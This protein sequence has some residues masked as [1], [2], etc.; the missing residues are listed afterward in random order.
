MVKGTT[1][2]QSGGSITAVSTITAGSDANQVVMNGSNGTFHAGTGDKQVSI[3]AADATL[4]AGSADSVNAVKLDGLTGSVLAGVSPTSAKGSYANLNSDG[5]IVAYGADHDNN[6][7][8]AGSDGSVTATGD[9]TAGALP[10]GTEDSTNTGVQV[11]SD[12]N[13][14]ATGDVNVGAHWDDTT[15]SLV[16]NITLDGNTGNVTTAEGKFIAGTVASESASSVLDASGLTVTSDDETAKTVKVTGSDATITAQ[17]GT[18]KVTVSGDDGTITSTGN[19]TAGA[20]PTAD[21]QTATGV[22]LASA[23]GDV[24]ATGDVKVGAH[25]DTKTNS[26]VSNIT[27]D[28]AT[29][30]ITTTGAISGEGF[31]G[32]IL[33]A[34]DDSTDTKANKIELN[35]TT[36]VSTFGTTEG[37]NVIIQRQ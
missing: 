26:L 32:K 24:T 28:G 25:W 13:V 30:D 2:V 21:A 19:I 31:S 35:G 4:V 1:S 29:G 12:G 22:E 18:N 27:L 37:Q 34:Y 6:V 8:I 33:T 5:T 14:T 3:N 36:G 17:N 20:L 15:S 16:S 7:Q 23:T 9:I 10:T 11:S